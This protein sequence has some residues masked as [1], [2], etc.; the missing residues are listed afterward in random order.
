MVLY[1]IISYC[2]ILYY[3]YYIVL[4]YILFYYN[5]LYYDISYYFIPFLCYCLLTIYTWIFKRLIYFDPFGCL[6]IM[7]ET[8]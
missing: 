7:V 5:I 4:Y 2:I 6:P 8:A 3:I 1:Y